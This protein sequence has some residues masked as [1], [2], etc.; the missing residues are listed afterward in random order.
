MILWCDNGHSALENMRRDAA[1]LDRL[2]AAVDGTPGAEPVLRLFGFTPP[3]ITLGRAQ[4]PERTLDLDRCRSDGVLW[5][6]RPTGGRAIFH[7]EE[8]TYSLAA[9]IADSEWGGRLDAAYERASRLVHASLIRLGI[10]A[11]LVRAR[12]PQADARAPLEPP[13]D[14]ARRSCFAATARHEIELAGRKLVGSA[15]RRTAGALIQQG[16]VLL[17]DSHLRLTDYLRLDP[18]S[19]ARARAALAANAAPAGPY[20]RVDRGIERWGRAIVAELGDARVVAGDG[21]LALLD[22]RQ[23]AGDQNRWTPSLA[24][25]ASAAEVK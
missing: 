19:R 2:D 12:R 13:N 4:D 16:S 23:T 8:W 5:A 22:R 6:V 24:R 9:R 14:P 3:G 21:G 20:L 15:Q 1:L 25:S 18:S 7:D 11:E 10:P 17:G